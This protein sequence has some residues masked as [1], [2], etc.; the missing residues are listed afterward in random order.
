MESEGYRFQ[1]VDA[2]WFPTGK[3]HKFSTGQDH[4]LCDEEN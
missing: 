4:K 2:T 1:E 3:T